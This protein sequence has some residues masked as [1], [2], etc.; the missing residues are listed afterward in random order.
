MTMDDDYD[1]LDRELTEEELAEM[2]PMPLV[3]RARFMAGLGRDL[4]ALTYGL[5]PDMVDRW[6]T[7]EAEPDPTAA[8]YLRAILN[9]PEA[10]AAAYNKPGADKTAAE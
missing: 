4:F 1:P 7:G 8:A 3:M 10:V 6:E 9:D 5:P 2:R